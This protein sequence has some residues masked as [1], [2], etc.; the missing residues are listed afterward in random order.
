MCSK[1]KYGKSGAVQ[2]CAKGMGGSYHN[3]G[4]LGGLPGKSNI[5]DKHWG[6]IGGNTQAMGVM[7][8]E[9][10]I[11]QN[12]ICKGPGI[13]ENR[14]FWGSKKNNP[15]QCLKCIDR[16]KVFSDKNLL[17]K[18]NIMVLNIKFGGF[19]TPILPDLHNIYT[20]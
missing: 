20:V 13:R 7:D 19:H 1:G 18:N 3:L 11:L 5:Q 4:W 9:A 6:W 14:C 8:R 17:K 16:G 10:K 15:L 12:S 2:E